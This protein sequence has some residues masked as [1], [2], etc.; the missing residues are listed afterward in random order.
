MVEQ[1]GPG[2]GAPASW[3]S[4]RRLLGRTPL[5]TFVV[6]PLVVVGFE[7]A[8]RRRVGVADARFLP[9]LAWGYVQY[10]LTGDYRRQQRAGGPGFDNPPDRLLQTGPYAYTRNPMYLGHLI[11]L[12]GLALSSRSPLA[13]A[14]WL[15]NLAWF[16]RRVLYDEARLRA[17]FGAEFTDYCAR[18]RR[19]IPF[20]V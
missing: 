20:A 1:R 2:G 4:L 16:H 19:W 9:L 15:V 10:R 3:P 6:Y 17:K 14:L 7:A 18:V 11:F 12:L 5:R 13:W 8:R